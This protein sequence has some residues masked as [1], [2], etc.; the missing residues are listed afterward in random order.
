MD[1]PGAK[2][3][4]AN[5]FR[6]IMRRRLCMHA[7][8]GFGRW[9]L[10]RNST[11]ME[12]VGKRW[13]C[14]QFHTLEHPL[15][16]LSSAHIMGKWHK[17][18]INGELITARRATRTFWGRSNGCRARTDERKNHSGV[19]GRGIGREKGQ[20][21][22]N[23]VANGMPDVDDDDEIAPHRYCAAESIKSAPQKVSRDTEFEDQ[24]A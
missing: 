7:S 16:S 17:N 23:S 22:A 2:N 19:G 21:L 8:T 4:M 3:A 13:R 24:V 18:R 15:F 10:A 5:H 11:W 1:R 14:W 20:K 6:G 12:R 9:T